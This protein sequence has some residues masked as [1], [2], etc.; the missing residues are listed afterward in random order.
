[1]EEIRAFV[2]IEL[3]AGIKS[4]L[5]Q[6]QEMLKEKIATPHLRWVDP[7][8]VHLTLKFLGNV[9]LDRIQEITAALREA[10]AGLSPFVMEVSGLGCFPTTN[11]PRVIWVGV[12]EETGRL[13]RLQERVEGS[14]AALGFKPEGRAF[15]PHLTLGRVRKGAHAGAR[16][17][18]GGIVSAT[19]VGDLGQMEVGEISLMKS[20]L[21]P[22]GAQHSRLETIALER[23]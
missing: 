2:A 13:K 9:P 14:L 5:T 21:L 8:N 12:Q 10:C 7:A 17:I 6:V 20:K 11:N 15:H 22:S 1:M 16:R 3:S 18:I 19:S 4:E 23:G